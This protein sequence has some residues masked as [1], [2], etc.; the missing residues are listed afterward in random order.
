MFIKAFEKVD[1]VLERVSYYAIYVA[2]VITLIM[3]CVTTYGV[4]TR[5][6]LHRPEHF[7]YEIGIFCLISSV[8]LS[9]AYIQRQGRNLRADYF[10]NRFGPKGQN[11]LLNIF[12][13][14]IALPYLLPLIWKSCQDAWY[15]LSIGE[16]TYSAW[17]PPAGPIKLFVP[18]GAAL[19]S[20]VLIAE[21]I[22][23]IIALIKNSY[24]KTAT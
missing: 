5:Y 9:M 7:T 12:T 1:H 16:R 6:A 17:G 4:A 11:I 8:C 3:A 15:S 10:S 24:E 19:L 21:L 22:H 18:I 13:P 14:L 23:G 2:G 20:L